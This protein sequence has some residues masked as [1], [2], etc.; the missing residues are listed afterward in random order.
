[1]GEI[2]VRTSRLGMTRNPPLARRNAVSVLLLSLLVWQSP[3]AFGDFPRADEF[4]QRVRKALQLDYQIQKDFSYLER[5]RDIRISRLGKVTIGPL[6]TFEVYPS[7]QPGRTYKR[8][9]EIEGKPLTPDELKRRDAEHLRDLQQEAERAR[10]ET[11]QQ[12]AE[13][14]EKAEAERRQRDA[15]LDDAVAVFAPTFVAREIIDGARIL[16]ADVKPR[17]AAH[18]TTRE[19]RWMKHFD[20]RIWVDESDYQVVKL[21]MRAFEDVTIG[22]GIVGRLYKGSRLHFSRRRFD[23]AWVPSEVTYQASG[24][25]LLF[26]PFQFAVTTTYSNYKRR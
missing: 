12:R 6:R 19:G 20:G 21:E 23:G 17:T 24:R 16:A 4:A 18:V 3:H 1:M 13:R 8:L 5:R 9:I 11:A 7:E 14:L 25:T 10:T 22:W 15:I 26:R 2:R